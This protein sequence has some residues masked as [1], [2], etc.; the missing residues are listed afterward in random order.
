MASR[1]ERKLFDEFERIDSTRMPYT[2]ENVF[3]FMNRVDRADWARVREELE[4]WYS[5]YPD[6]DNDLR[7]RFQSQREDQHYGAWWELYVHTFY[8]RLG[9]AA[10]VHPT[11][12]NGT[13]PD[14]LV[15]RGGISTYVE[16][17]AIPAN[18]RS[19]HEAWIL[20]CTDKARHTDFLLELDIE[21]EGTE[22]PKADAIRTPLER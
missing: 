21:Q 15:T 16:C 3:Q 18:P 14:F 22:Q 6:S 2:D 13:K 12:P 9:Y 8:R 7:N 5:E 17:K 11:M 20:D 1:S 10:D 4:G 19:P